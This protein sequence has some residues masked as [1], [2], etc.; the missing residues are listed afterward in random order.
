MYAMLATSDTPEGTLS[1]LPT[2]D[3]D[4]LT[5]TPTL[6]AALEGPERDKWMSAIHAELQNIKA[7]DV[8]DLI[9]PTH[10]PVDNLL[11]NKIVLRRKRGASGQIERYK[12]RFTAR[13]DHQR[14]SIDYEETFAPVV[15]SASIRVVFALAATMGLLVRHLDVTAAFLNG[16][17]KETVYMRQPKGF[18][19]PGKESW[20]WKLKKALYGLKQ[21]GREWYNCIDNFF[22]DNLGL[23]RTFADHSVYVFESDSCVLIVPLYVDDLL[24]AYDNED[25]MLFIKAALEERFKMVD[26]GPASWVLGMRVCIDRQNGTVSIDQSQYIL[27]VLQRFGMADC[28]PASTPLP[29][30]TI[31][32][33]APDDDI[34]ACSSF[35]YLQALGSVMYAMLGT[36]PDIAYA[37]ST[38][39]RYASCPGTQHVNALK[40]L[41]RYLK[42]TI[43]YG[44]IYSRDGGS[45]LACESDLE[46]DAKA[47]SGYTDSDY[48]MD[49]ETRRS[50]SGAVFL[51]AGGP[52]SWSSRLQSS[53]SQSS[54]EA[55]YVASTKAAKETIWL[56][57]LMHDLKQD[58]SHPTPLFIDNRGA[59][60]LAKNPI[61]HNNTKHIDVRHHY[62]RE[63]VADGSISLR[64]VASADN[65]ADICTKPLGKV[66]FTL[67][68]SLLGV[69]H[70][71]Q[72][73]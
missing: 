66:K 38:L 62:V 29:E 64:P 71:P 17:L 11:G 39:S 33:S 63:C 67:L 35:P 12:A 43:A 68:R 42:G 41:L 70:I 48:A 50:V 36:R 45:L 15:K 47:I 65:I 51:L 18:E 4:D 27:K 20:V 31:L 5:D 16:V 54:T 56:R 10:E 1:T 40:H 26:A 55:E 59:L 23:T 19:E 73:R 72:R 3:T 61:H 7:E 69:V 49:P 13:G 60:L 57:R 24:I 37:V 44:I 22:T 9:D 25:R 32:R 34:K 14:E 8:Y 52:I 58:V 21:G 53:V 2:P 46:I 28:K 6:K 30:K